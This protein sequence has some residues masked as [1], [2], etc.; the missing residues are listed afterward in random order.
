MKMKTI[1][2]RAVFSSILVGNIALGGTFFDDFNRAT[3]PTNAMS[4]FNGTSSG[5]DIGE[6]YIVVGN[7]YQIWENKLRFFGPDNGNNYIYNTNAITGTSGTNNFSISVD[8]MPTHAFDFPGDHLGVVFNVQSNSNQCYYLRIGLQSFQWVFNID[9]WEGQFGA[10]ALTEPLVTGEEYT[11]TVSSTAAPYQF[12]CTL[13]RKSNGATI[14]SGTSDVVGP[15]AELDDGYGGMYYFSTIWRSRAD[16]FTVTSSAI[17]S[18]PSAYE[19]WTIDKG[20][21][22]GVNNAPMDNPD[23]IGGSL[24][25]NLYEFGLGGDPL[26]AGDEGLAPSHDVV[27][28]GGTNWFSYVYP[29]LSDANSGLVYYLELTE[30]LGAPAWANAGYFLAG[31]GTFSPGFDAVTNAVPT[32]ADTTFVRLVIEAQ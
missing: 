6:G 10:G 24:L 27:N 19:Q 23:G 13:V 3:V 2:A 21:T 25:N 16:N 7:E 18:G 5:A 17:A 1:I 12:D 15:G 26:D 30:N 31:T 32:E 20:L 4:D 28:V 11:L 22:P 14:G 29:K 8:I 9:G